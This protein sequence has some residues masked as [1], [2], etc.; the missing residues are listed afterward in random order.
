MS[1]DTSEKGLGAV[2]EQ[3]ENQR[4]HPIAYAS[5]TLNKS[6]QNY[7]QLEK[8]ILSIV[9][10]CTKFHDYIYGKP[11]HMYNDYLPL[12]SIFTKSIVKSPP[13][14]RRF[15]LRLQKYN[16]EMHYMQGS[17]LTVADTLS[18]ANLTD[19]QTEV[20]ENELNSFVHSII[21]NYLI[22]HSRLQQFQDETQKD[23]TL[24]MVIQFIQDGWPSEPS[25]LPP[26]VRLYFTYREDLYYINGLVL[27]GNRIVIPKN[28]MK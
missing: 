22:S 25:R 24:R 18:R 10:A 13:R 11:F 12:K 20:N 26:N 14:I 9:F 4:W 1:C 15:L 8:E 5:H 23:N 21:S 28:K 6:D 17:L 27:K 7:C 19:C 3:K 2:L 16:F